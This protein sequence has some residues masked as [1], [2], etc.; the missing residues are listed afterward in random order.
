MK[1]NAEHFHGLITRLQ[2]V[3]SEIDYAQKACLQAGKMECQLLNHL[4]VVKEPVNMNEL[5]KVLNVSHSRITRIMDNLVSKKLVLRKPSEKDRR[6]WFAIIT[7]KGKKLA[8]NSRQ[9]VV[10]H[11]KKIIAQIPEKN[12]E[13][14]YKALK[15]YVEKY[16]EVLKATTAE[17]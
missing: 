1:V 17:I 7:D 13:D 14:V 12:V 4:F 8:E 9:T 3:L 2:V 5:A 10:D 6:C 11:Q 16:E 15:I